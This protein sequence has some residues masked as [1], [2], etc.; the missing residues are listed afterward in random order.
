MAGFSQVLDYLDV[1]GSYSEVQRG[2]ALVVFDV[3]KSFLYLGQYLDDLKASN[4]ACNM[5]RSFTLLCPC[6]DIRELFD[7][8][9]DHLLTLGFDRIMQRLQILFVLEVDICALILILDLIEQVSHHCQVI[10]LNRL[11]ELLIPYKLGV[12]PVLPRGLVRV[13][14]KLGDSTLLLQDT[15]LL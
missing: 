7:Q 9:F 4:L 11:N 1:L 8:Q 12:P 15:H 14:Q 13:L 5:Q 10:S 2:V 6:V 3:H